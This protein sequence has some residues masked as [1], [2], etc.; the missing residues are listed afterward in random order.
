[1]IG[2]YARNNTNSNVATWRRSCHQLCKPEVNAADMRRQRA[3]RDKSRITGSEIDA[4]SDSVTA[5]SEFAHDRI[6]V[7]TT[8]MRMTAAAA[9]SGREIVTTY[10]SR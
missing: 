2:I 10:C 5:T 3:R 4:D 8:N 6:R 1:V 7:T 9:S